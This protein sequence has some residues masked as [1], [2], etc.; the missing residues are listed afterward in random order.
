MV[1]TGT[2]DKGKIFTFARH[3]TFHLRDGWL[4]KGLNAL[5]NDESYLS[6]E[7][8]HHKLGIGINMLK[9]I[10][11]WLQATNL[12]QG[13]EPKSVQRRKL[14]LTTLANV[15]FQ[16]DPYFEDIRTLW[17]LHIELASNI[18]LATFWYWAFNE[19]NQQEFTEERLIQGIQR[20]LE[21][22]AAKSIAPSSLRKDA[23]CFLH[24]YLPSDT[25]N[26]GPSKSSAY[27]VLESP[28]SLLGLIKRS[29]LS[30]HYKFQIGPHS[31]L[32][33]SIFTYCLFKFREVTRPNEVAVSLEDIR[34]GPCSPGRLLCLD[35]H[36]I[37]QYLEELEYQTSYASIIRTAELNMIMLDRARTSHDLL[38][39]CYHNGD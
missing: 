8:A 18:I 12:V 9:S 21:E 30:E 13:S 38:T 11:Y 24:T 2:R 29:S 15:I 6:G 20:F 39:E 22:N 14:Q 31:N 25:S 32:P 34:W 1:N 5:Q 10:I 17:L 3:E 7:D 37:L 35:M 36:S 33:T 19:F 23:R 27:D 26:E 16:E 4:F 28:L